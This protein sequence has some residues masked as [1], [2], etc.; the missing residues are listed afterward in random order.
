MFILLCP[1]P[2][3]EN[4]LVNPERQEK[5][6]SSFGEALLKEAASNWEFPLLNVYP[7]CLDL[8]TVSA[9]RHEQQAVKLFYWDDR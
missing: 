4:F 2:G 1:L 6:H 7:L 9:H 3:E 8:V 5:N